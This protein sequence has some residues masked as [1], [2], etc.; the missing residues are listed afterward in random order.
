MSSLYFMDIIQHPIVFRNANSFIEKKVN[1]E[2]IR[3]ISDK[4]INELLASIPYQSSKNVY[5]VNPQ[6]KYNQTIINGYGNCSNLSFG[7]SYKLLNDSISFY[8]I[9]YYPPEDW[10]LGHGHTT[11]ILKIDGEDKIVDYLEGGIISNLN[12]ENIFSTHQPD[13]RFQSLNNRK[14]S[15]NPYFPEIFNYQIGVIE[16][17]EIKDYFNFLNIVYFSFGNKKIEKY[18]FDAL[19]LFTGFYPKIILISNNMLSTF[20]IIKYKFYLLWFRSLFPS[21]ILILLFD[22]KKTRK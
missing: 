19:A 1:L 16:D 7:A 12:K 20:E 4:Y 21:L 6:K 11:M 5:E 10:R 22:A 15:I 2:N 18:F 3:S 13:L 9:H 14:D 8:L 17:K